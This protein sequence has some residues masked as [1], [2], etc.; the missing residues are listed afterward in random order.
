MRRLA[1]VTAALVAGVMAAAPGAAIADGTIQQQTRDNLIAAAHGEAYAHA[2]YW[3]YGQQAQNEQQRAIA[4]LFMRTS[5]DELNDHFAKLAQMAGLI[6]DNVTNLTDAINGETAESTSVYP[7]FA[8]DAQAAGDTAAADFWTELAHD[9]GV[10][11]AAFTQA[12]TAIQHPFSGVRVPRPPAVDPFP[13]QA[14]PAKSTDATVLNDLSMTLHGE[15]F[16][17]AKY[18]MYGIVARKTGHPRLARLW[19]GTANV[20]LLEHFAEATSFAGLV[21][22]SATNLRD[23]IQGEVTEATS[24]YITFA[25]QARDAGDTDAAELFSELARDEAGHAAKFIHALQDLELPH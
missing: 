5:D 7:G 13:I 8:N 16:A 22:D 23:A 14:G 21:Q 2:K 15:S 9:E 1:F 3:A 24:T 18:T 4:R 17:N 20:E 10:H 25:Q 11:A 6:A 19:M 12:R